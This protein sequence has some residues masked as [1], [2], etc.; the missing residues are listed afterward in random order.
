MTR[1]SLF[2]VPLDLL[3]MEQTVERCRTLIEERRPVQH[4]VLNASKVVMMEDVGGLRDIIARCDLVNAD[5]ISVVWAG[6]VF[7]LDVPERVTGIDLMERLLGLSE[8]AGYPVYLLGARQEVLDRFTSIVRERFPSIAIAGTHDGYFDDD[9]AIA[10]DIAR[11]G[12]R[13]LFVAITSPR[14]EQFLSQNLS[15]MGPVFAMGVGG[16]FDVW[17]GVTRRAPVWMQRV[18][19]EWFYRFAQEPSRMWRRYLLGNLRFLGLVVAE[20]ANRA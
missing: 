5:G 9:A 10:E 6:R 2:G 8:T 11:S 12:A 7:G 16:S 3:T 14:K 20:K 18:G 17:A 4:V 1:G 13:V 15:R 19:L